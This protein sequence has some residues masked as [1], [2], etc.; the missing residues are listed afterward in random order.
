MSPLCFWGLQNIGLRKIRPWI[1][2]MNLMLRPRC[3]C[4]W[5]VTLGIASLIFCNTFNVPTS[6]LC[7]HFQTSLKSY[8]KSPR[9]L[10]LM[11]IYLLPVDLTAVP[12]T[13]N[14]LSLRPSSYSISSACWLPLQVAL[15]FPI[16]S[17]HHLSPSCSITLWSQNNS[18][19]LSFC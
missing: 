1:F 17:L 13:D 3:L 9:A 19:S 15:D 8:L 4:W 16:R 2:W 6:S 5:R 7:V 10:S 18:M 12:E 11:S 14:L